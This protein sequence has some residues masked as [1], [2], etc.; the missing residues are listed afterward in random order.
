[1]KPEKESA[2][3]DSLLPAQD[4]FEQWRSTRKKR[5]RIPE[6]LWEAAIDLHPSY[7]TCRI[8]KALR[9]DFKELKRRIHERSSRSTP[10]EFVEMNV[11][12]LFSAGQCV[13][14]VRSPA[15]F[16]LKIQADAAF[17]PQLSQVI[18]CF[19]SKSR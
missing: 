10:S 9:L 8:A 14:E 7:S 2:S 13:I 18:S 3:P 17:P 11:E 6:S 1:M 12:R 19:L 4:A 16:E 5:D 15:G